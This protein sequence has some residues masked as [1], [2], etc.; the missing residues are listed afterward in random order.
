MLTVA[1]A[2]GG[3][4]GGALSFEFMIGFAKLIG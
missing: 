1:S 4:V 2:I 3:P